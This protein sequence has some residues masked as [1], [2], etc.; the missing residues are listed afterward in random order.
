MSEPFIGQVIAVGF[1]FAPEGWLLCNGQLVSISE[2]EVLY[3]L[4]G[5]TYGGN[6]TTNFA[7]PDLRSRTPAC[8]GTGAGLSTYVLGQMAGTENV[9]LMPGQIGQH[10]H[11]L[12]TSSQPG[13]TNTPAAS[14]VLGQGGQAA[15]HVYSA[16]ATNTTLN[17]ASIGSSGGNIPHENRQP[18]QVVNFI[19]AAYGIFP[20][21]S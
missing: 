2:Y 1:S 9:T 4:I 21:R 14:V 11:P 17:S 8:M 5:T 6:G 16:A 3:D 15:V 7:V 18:F 13:S 10:S 12:L 19:I 20:S